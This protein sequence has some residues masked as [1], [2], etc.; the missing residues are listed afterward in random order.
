MMENARVTM[1]AE[2]A[3]REQRPHGKPFRKGTSGN[4]AGKPK[5]TRNK[6]TVLLEAISDDDLS[7]IVKELVTKAKSG[8]LTA[9]KILL[10]RL[11]PPLRSLC[12]RG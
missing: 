4:P 7:A 9:I 1:P 2:N 10:D 8:D 11:I 12:G 3:A 5:G 6:A